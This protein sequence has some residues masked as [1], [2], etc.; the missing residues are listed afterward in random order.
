MLAHRT[1][2]TLTVSIWKCE[3]LECFVVG[4]RA[5][6]RVWPSLLAGM[7]GEGSAAESSD[8]PVQCASHR[9]NDVHHRL[10]GGSS[11]LS[12][13]GIELASCTSSSSASDSWLA[14]V[15]SLPCH[16]HHCH[17]SFAFNFYSTRNARIASAVLATAI[18]SV[19]LSVRHTPVLCQN[20]GT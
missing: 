11:R 5:G 19:C 3:L 7:R 9:L 1:L 6:D 20:D 15:P 10:S 8:G 16:L 14:Q 13:S 12:D 18:P 4:E 2:L 17:V